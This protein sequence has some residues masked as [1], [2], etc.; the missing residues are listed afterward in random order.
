MND[1][2]IKELK[3]EKGKILGELKDFEEMIAKEKSLRS[4]LVM[5]D[6]LLSMYG[7]AQGVIELGSSASES[8]T[9]K[10]DIN[11][12]WEDKCLYVLNQLGEGYAA[13]VVK[14]MLSIDPSLNEERTIAAVAFYLSKLL[15][16]GK[17]K[18]VGQSG[19]KY[20]YGLK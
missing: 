5:I 8:I 10:Y 19:R 7:S 4:R 9:D 16:A 14:K 3:T 20:K 1:I 13:D 18:K 17:I 6:A 2:L 12:T 11:F 15:R